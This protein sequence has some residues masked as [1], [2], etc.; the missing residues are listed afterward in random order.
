MLDAAWIIVKAACTGWGV[1]F[2]ATL[3]PNFS[4]FLPLSSIPFAASSEAQLQVM[5]LT[6]HICQVLVF[7]R[8]CSSSFL[9][10]PLC[11][12]SLLSLPL[13]MRLP[14]DNS[15]WKTYRRAGATRVSRWLLNAAFA[16]IPCP[17][18][19]EQERPCCRP[20]RP[21]QLPSSALLLAGRWVSSLGNSASPAKNTPKQPSKADFCHSLDT[22]RA[23]LSSI[24][25]SFYPASKGSSICRQYLTLPDKLHLYRLIQTQAINTRRLCTDCRHA[26]WVPLPGQTFQ[27]ALGKTPLGSL[28]SAQTALGHGLRA[29]ISSVWV[30]LWQRHHPLTFSILYLCGFSAV[31]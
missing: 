23:G 9:Q 24:Y 25:F 13:L 22:K 4:P 28:C 12:L 31:I 3:F 1:P 21:L 8:S 29:A 10:F 26:P 17:S 16:A 19:R 7:Q 6:L 2:L 30:L 14:C 5:L 20:A 11:A 27:K 15:C 18:R